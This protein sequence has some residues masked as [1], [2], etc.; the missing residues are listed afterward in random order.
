MPTQMYQ[1]ALIPFEEKLHVR[2]IPKDVRTFN[3]KGQEITISRFHT[4]K[5][6][7]SLLVCPRCNHR[8]YELL[9]YPW[10]PHREDD[11]I[12]CCKKCDPYVKNPYAERTDMDDRGITAIIDYH[13]RKQTAVFEELGVHLGAYFGVAPRMSANEKN[14]INPM[15]YRLLLWQKPKHMRMLTFKRMLVRFQLLLSLREDAIDNKKRYSGKEIG[16]YINKKSI[17]EVI[18]RYDSEKDLTEED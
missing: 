9:W 10:Y 14:C 7:R 13:I 1:D 4:G 6:L 18:Q 11:P 12:Y 5:G 15:D 16:L 8:A 2:D 17:D 3:W